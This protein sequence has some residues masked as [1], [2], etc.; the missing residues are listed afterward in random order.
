MLIRAWRDTVISAEEQQTLLNN[1]AAQ[2]EPSTL[3]L[4]EAQLED[5]TRTEASP[6]K[7]AELKAQAIGRAVY[8]NLITDAT[9]G[10]LQR[11][12]Q[13]EG[14]TFQ[15]AQINAACD[16]ISPATDA[17][18]ARRQRRAIID[19][20]FGEYKIDNTTY[21]ELLLREDHA[22]IDALR[23]EYAGKNQAEKLALIKATYVTR[24]VAQHTSHSYSDAKKEKSHNS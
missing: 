7:Q 3:P 8:L 11:E 14:K 20:A 12:I 4:L 9:Y 19:T 23:T 10:R 16:S 6:I 13:A 24:L 18:E 17:A 15:V 2:Q 5:I 1:F 21:G 22:A